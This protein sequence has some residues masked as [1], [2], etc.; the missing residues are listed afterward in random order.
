VHV[1]F[2]ACQVLGIVGSEIEIEHTFNVVGVITNL[3]C[4]NLKIDKLDCFI[5]VVINWFNDLHI[6]CVVD[7]PQNT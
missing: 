3:R 7:K 4:S 6:G 5:L 2:L 1:V